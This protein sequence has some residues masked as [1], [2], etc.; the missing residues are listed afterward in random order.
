LTAS[1][2]EL[3]CHL[4]LDLPDALFD[5][6]PQYLLAMRQQ[7]GRKRGFEL[8]QAACEQTRGIAFDPGHQRLAGRQREDT[9]RLDAKEAGRRAALGVDVGRHLFDGEQRIAQGVDLV[10]HHEG[11]ALAT[12]EVVAPDGHVRLGHPGVGTDDEHRGVRRRQQPQGEFRLGTECIQA[13]RV[14]HDQALPQQRVRVVDQR[15]SPGRHVDQSIAIRHRVVF[16]RRFVPQAERTRLVDGHPAG[17]HDLAQRIR[18]LFGLRDVQ[19]H[20]RP[21]VGPAAQLGQRLAGQP[22]GDRQQGQRDRLLG[23]VGQ[24]HGAHRRA[25]RRRRQ[26]TTAGVGE[27]DRVDQFRFTAR[28]LRNEGDPQLLGRQPVAQ[29]TDQR[30]QRVVG[31]ALFGQKRGHPVQ[32]L[33]HGV[34]PEAE[35]IEAAREG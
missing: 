22:S 32:S 35:F 21:G 6:L 8:A 18:Q 29:V 10:E 13:G 33:S 2:A 5:Q 4:S 30:I 28:E 23:V 14:Q 9:S 25:A 12:A 11:R 19:R 7:L 24:F 17:A 26:H 20:M 3:A 15:V 34:P 1:V 16:G 27:K 31:Q